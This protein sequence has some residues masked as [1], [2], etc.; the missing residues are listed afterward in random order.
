[1]VGQDRARAAV[2]FSLAPH[3]SDEMSVRTAGVLVVAVL[4]IGGMN[5]G[6][7]TNPDGSVNGKE[8]LNRSAELGMEQVGNTLDSTAEAAG[9][10]AASGIGSS[11]VL[12]AGA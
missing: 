7:V 11:K 6:V 9:R 1:M 10:G 8:T 2:A 12:A 5:G 4:A 3:R